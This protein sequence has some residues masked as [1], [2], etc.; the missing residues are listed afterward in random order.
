MGFNGRLYLKTQQCYDWLTFTLLLIKAGKI[1]EYLIVVCLLFEELK[2][3]EE[4][5]NL[6][7]FKDSSLFNLEFSV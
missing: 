6:C 2:K 4:I 3:K 5:Y 7:S 1:D